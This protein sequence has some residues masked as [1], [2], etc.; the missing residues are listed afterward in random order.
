VGGHLDSWDLA[1]G[2]HDD[3]TGV[4]QSIEVVRALKALGLR[5]RRTVRVVL[6]MAEEFGG[7]GANQYAAQAK[8]KGEKHFAA[9][10]SDSGGFAPIGFGVS[11]TDKQVATVKRWAPYLAF[12]HADSIKKG[13]GGTDIA[14]LAPLGTVTIG[15]NP[16]GSHYFDFHHSSR[17]R[18]EAVNREELHAGAGA[19]TLLAYLLAEKGL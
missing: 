13:G 1:T 16:D 15:Y 3:G 4:V 14:P 12:F 6:F 9:I 18:I 2:A 10:E 8:A 19:I 7:L 11:G 17:D 5:P